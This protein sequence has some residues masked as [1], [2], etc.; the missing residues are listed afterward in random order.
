MSGP[1]SWQRDEQIKEQR[2]RAQRK[3]DGRKREREK[4]RTYIA[5]FGRVPQII[6]GAAL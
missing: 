1:V 2:A 4:R 6:H 5:S 3:E